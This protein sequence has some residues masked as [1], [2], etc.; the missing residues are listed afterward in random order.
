MAHCVH[1][2]QALRVHSLAPTGRRCVSQIY[3]LCL[4]FTGLTSYDSCGWTWAI[5]C[6]GDKSHEPD[7]AG[8]VRVCKVSSMIALAPHTTSV[9]DVPGSKLILP[10]MLSLAFR[11][12]GYV[13]QKRRK[14]TTVCA[15]VCFG[16]VTVIA[17]GHQS[18]VTKF[19]FP[20]E[21]PPPSGRVLIYSKWARCV[22]GNA[23]CVRGRSL[24]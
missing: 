2:R 11:Q 24:L 4:P 8:R 10:V 19:A 17:L 1:S 22:S 12:E 21:P 13:G 14:Y 5:E 6:H 16:A 7:H 9:Q 23:E 20:P 15:C 3:K 18:N